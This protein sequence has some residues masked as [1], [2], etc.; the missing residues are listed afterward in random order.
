MPPFGRPMM[1]EPPPLEEGLERLQ[2]FLRRLLGE[3][4]ATGQGAAGHL[5]GARGPQLQ[6]VVAALDDALPA[7]QPP[8]RRN[9][10]AVPVGAVVLEVYGGGGTGV[11]R[12]AVAH[13]RVWEAAR[14]HRGSLGR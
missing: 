10:L 6:H 3:E 9:A 13:R 14:V 12:G 7:P 2:C 4:V 8:Q 11:P 5:P 1:W